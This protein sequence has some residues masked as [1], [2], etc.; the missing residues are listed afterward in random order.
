[1]VKLKHLKQ[2]TIK[3]FVEEVL[4]SG[5]WGFG[6]PITIGKKKYYFAINIIPYKCKTCGE[7]LYKEFE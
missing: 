7:E 2:K 5:Q 3:K 4:K 6:E 1:M